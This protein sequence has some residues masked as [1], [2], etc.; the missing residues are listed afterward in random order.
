M[1]AST[2]PPRARGPESGPRERAR[3]V[4]ERILPSENPA[5]VVYGVIVIGALLAAES[6]RH[7]SYADAIAS[8]LIA[9]ALYWLAH[10]YTTVL[11]GRL[12]E[13]AR[14]TWGALSRAL[15]HDGAIVR[16]AAI[17]L[18]ALVVCWAVG[19]TQQTGVTAA[20]WSAAGT[21][22]LFELSA[23]VRS[24]AAPGELAIEVGVGATM[25]LAILALKVV[26][27]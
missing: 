11:G 20:V 13:G 5:G 4:A 23:G 14:L 21:L 16:G 2:P 1:E 22:I 12:G 26:L 8:A 15:V 24:H 3:K 25:G 17:P 9:T 19:V 6:D 10:G 18:L 7:E 27:H